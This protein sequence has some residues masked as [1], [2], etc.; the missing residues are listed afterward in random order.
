MSRYHDDER[1][2]LASLFGASQVAIEDDAVVLDGRSLPTVDDVI[3]TSS[4]D[5][6]PEEL[7]RRVES[8][9][10]S[11]VE[12][13]AGGDRDDFARDVQ[14]TF[15]REWIRYGEVLPEHE[16]EFRRYF[17]L[18]DLDALADSR[19]IDLGDRFKKLS[20]SDDLPYWHFL[21]ER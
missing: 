13:S 20:I 10:G 4:P 16:A 2:S 21:A 3:H 18:V 9:R 12:S 7:R 14:S 5:G 1:E 19:L 8:A 11:G 15:G 6:W 17:D